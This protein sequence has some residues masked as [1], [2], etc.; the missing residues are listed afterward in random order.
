[1]WDRPEKITHVEESYDKEWWHV[2]CG[3]IGFSFE[4]KWGFEPKVGDVVDCQTKGNLIRG[5]ILNG[6]RVFYKDDVDLDLEQEEIRL[7]TDLDRIERFKK[8]RP[9][10]DKAYAGLPPVFQRR[11]DKF[12]NT[13]GSSWR[14]TYEPYEMN[15]C[16][17]AVTIA[18]KME[19][20]SGVSRF[21]EMPLEEQEKILPSIRD[22]SGNS[23]GATVMLARLY[24]RDPELVVLQHGAL[25]PLVGCEEYG[26]P[27]DKGE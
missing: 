17:N 23:Y 4:K 15:V 14:W 2:T 26:C 20:E 27:H 19:T 3:S 22:E 13:K 12:R 11:I 10:L 24:L 5:V 7:K 25:T 21:Y 8:S 18:T 6:K 1:M 9:D 16:V